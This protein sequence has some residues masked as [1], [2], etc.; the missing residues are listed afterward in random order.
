[1]NVFLNNEWEF[2]EKFDE[3]FLKGLGN[4]DC[5]SIPHICKET[6][7]NHWSADEYQMVCGYRKK[8]M[9][10]KEWQGKRIF[11]RFMGAAH[12]AVV[13]LNEIEIARHG[14][15]Y[16]EFVA[17]LTEYAKLGEANM[18]TVKLDT[19][20]NL[21]IPPFGFVIDYMTY[22]GI[23]RDVILEVKENTYISDIFI[24]A[25]HKGKF[26]C[27]ITAD[28]STDGLSYSI[29]IMDMNGKVVLEQQTNE[30]NFGT[31]LADV[32]PWNVSRPDL[33]TC[34]V[35]LLR[36]NDIIDEK[37][38]RFGFRSAEFKTD[39]FYL[40]GRK[41]KLIGLNRH[42]SYPYVGYAMPKSMQRYDADIL[43]KE[44]GVNMVRTSHYPQSQY[45]IDRCDEL[46][47]VVF[48]EIP[49]WQHIGDE[50]WKAQAVVNTREM[51]MQY[52]NHPS[53]ILW[54]VRIN[55]SQDDD[56][57]YQKTNKIAHELDSTRATSGVRFIE[58][59]NLLEDVYAFNDFSHDG[60]NA[61][62]KGKKVTS[63][64][65]KAFI[66]SECNGHMYPTKAFDC[67]KHRLLHAKRHA[68]VVESMMAAEDIAGVTGWCMFDYNT[69]RDF[70]SG[71]GICYH[72][73][74]DMFRNP[75]L[76]AAVYASQGEE[77]DVCEVSASMDI[78]EHAA[79]NIG[80][81]YVFTNADLIKLYKN[82][83][84]VRDF[85]PNREE[86]RHMTHPPIIINDFVGEL[87]E[88]HENY[89]P[90]LAAKIK[91]LLLAIAKYGQSNLP[92]KYMLKAANLMIFHKL[93]FADGINLYGKYVAN[94]GSLA[95]K[96]RF[97]AVK[98]GKLV[99]SIVMQ[100]GSPVHIEAVPSHTELVEDGSYDVALVR[101]R[102]VDS[103]GNV[104][105][106]FMEPVE[107]KTTGDIEIIGPKTISLKGG[108]GGTYIR[109][110]RQNG[111]GILTIHN[112]QTEN[113][114]ISFSI[115]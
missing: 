30:A 12:E 97:D 31:V 92:F 32:K 110:T 72:G 87:L 104:V 47:I 66:V 64:M 49:G 80:D 7:Y 65:S 52:R 91:D 27:D 26:E 109:N 78:G 23:Y 105:P 99:N 114:S 96:Y 56:E 62:L 46:G 24:K 53:I 108:M 44:L 10:P 14:C 34:R 18:L 50:D 106:Y 107:L 58:K 36:D 100:P 81:V 83:E 48:T 86:Y 33:Y 28:G 94:W 45:F 75:K 102:A 22:G 17:E 77:R 95:V 1:M 112:N 40:N 60:T 76:A 25:D 39:G 20:E 101:I 11:V 88:K 90:R 8:L 4:A 41:L 9:I 15:G 79:G 16:T 68:A 54:G 84:F 21:N 82:D 55:E 43:K 5:V 37:T 19:R 51:V 71:D 67:E 93:K 59:S 3:N 63:D 61:G 57:L 13:Y 35:C 89:S 69:H 29:E 113:V 73:V 70:G 115:K 38:V 2:S 6:A 98:N 42:Q 103:F 111:E 74:M 85:L